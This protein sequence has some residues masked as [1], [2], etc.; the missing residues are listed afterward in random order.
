VFAAFPSLTAFDLDHTLR[1]ANVAFPVLGASELAIEP[2]FGWWV[3]IILAAITLASIWLTVTSP[4]ISGRGR[5]LLVLI[6]LLATLMLLL[7]WLRPAILSEGERETEGAIAVLMDKSLSAT[8]PSDSLGKSRWDVQQEVWEAIA[9]ATELKIG[10]SKIIPYFYDKDL[11]QPSDTDLPLLRKSFSVQPSGRLTDIGNA[12]A[13]VSK[14]QVLPPLRAVVLIGDATQ[15]RTPPLSDPLLVA[16][17]MAQLDQPIFVVGVGSRGESN[18][19]KDVALESLPEEI[20]AFAKKQITVPIMISAQGMTNVPIELTLVLKSPNKPDK[21][22]VKRTVFAQNKVDKL[23][24]NYPLIL[25][26]PGDYMLEAKVAVDAKEQVTSNNQ[27]IS[28]LTV[29]DGGVRAVVLEGQPRS[30]QQFLRMSLD[31]SKDFS[32]NYLW[33]PDKTEKLWPLNIER[34]ASGFKLTDFDVIII[35]DLDSKALDEASWNRITQRVNQGAGLMLLGG[36]YSFDAGGYQ[37]TA[38]RDAIPIKMSA[39]RQTRGAKIDSRF[40]FTEDV[41]LRPTRPHVITTLAPEP[42]N[43]KLWEGLKPMMKGMNRFQ[44]LSSNPGTQILLEGPQGQP[45][46]VISEY[47]AGRVFAFAGDTTWQWYRSGD[48]YRRAHQTFWRQAMLWLV[49]RNKLDEGFQMV[50][51][52]RRQ[53]I[54]A[55]PKIKIEWYGGSDNAVIPPTI[56]VALSRDG[57]FIKNLDISSIAEATR[58]VVASGLDSPGLYRAQLTSTDAKGKEYKSDL[59]FLVQDVSRE[60]TQPAADWRMMANLVAAGKTSGSELFL[61][62]DTGSL[63]TKLRE[64]QNMTKTTTIE[65][66]RLGDAAWDTWLYFAI[67]CGLMSVEWVLRKRWQLP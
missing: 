23:A 12:L 52:S 1:T 17:Q 22:L 45:A 38:L 25:D 29:R 27:S 3:V 54:D 7:G 5:A 42:E 62:E 48:E 39:N 47:G 65:R 49:N 32:V 55:A 20:K 18:I 34:S 31:M 63:I 16:R 67:F 28:F 9:T 6:R 58:E 57:Q 50:I 14:T 37:S 19:L 60:L 8:L 21:E 36:Y 30:E 46:L 15:T 4:G 43:Q 44:E 59:A 26:E 66:R 51:D 11:T 33:F 24:V 61:P 41:K 64:R 2:I 35:G 10:G 40:H 13:E 53:D 56:K